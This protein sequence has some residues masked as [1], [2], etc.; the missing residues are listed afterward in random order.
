MMSI[1]KS[2]SKKAK[3]TSNNFLDFTNDKLFR[4]ISE[5]KKNTILAGNSTSKSGKNIQ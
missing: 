4:Q 2:Q 1:K 3:D 5:K